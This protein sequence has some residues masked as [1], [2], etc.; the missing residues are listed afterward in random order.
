MSRLQTIKV[1]NCLLSQISENGVTK[2]DKTSVVDGDALSDVEAKCK[3]DRNPL[4][5]EGDVDDTDNPGKPTGGFEFEI[6]N[7]DGP[8]SKNSSIYIVYDSKCMECSTADPKEKSSCKLKV[9][10][11]TSKQEISLQFLLISII[12]NLRKILA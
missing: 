4:I 7:G 9:R 6:T 8:Y 5:T 11:S 1:L 10:A 2:T 3:P 12:Y